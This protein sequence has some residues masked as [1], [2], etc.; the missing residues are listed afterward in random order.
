MTEIRKVNAELLATLREIWIMERFQIHKIIEE[1]RK[2]LDI[3]QTFGLEN[4]LLFGRPEEERAYEKLAGRLIAIAP[5]IVILDTGSDGLP[6]MLSGLLERP[7]ADS[8]DPTFALRSFS[9]PNFFA[10]LYIWPSIDKKGKRQF[11]TY[12]VFISWQL[13]FGQGE[14]YERLGI[15]PDRWKILKTWLDRW[16]P[17]QP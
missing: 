10:T 6:Q 9:P 8:I 11:A 16:L 14:S 7:P 5:G 17:P 12:P 4:I 1:I 13:G 2:R 15:D 3:K